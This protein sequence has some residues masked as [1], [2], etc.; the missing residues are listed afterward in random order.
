VGWSS[1]NRWVERAREYDANLE[2]IKAEAIEEET[3][4]EARLWA[5]RFKK[6]REREFVVGERM[7]E[8]AEEMMEY[9]L[10]RTETRGEDGETVIVMPADWR[11]VDVVA[12]MNAASRLIRAAVGTHTEQVKEVEQ[13]TMIIGGKEI[14]F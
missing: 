12:F 3:T 13:Q 10:I 4:K 8:K 6:L 5:A 2:A 9:P 14:R 1:Q 7:I 11:P